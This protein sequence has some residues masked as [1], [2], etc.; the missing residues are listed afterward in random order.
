MECSSVREASSS[1][2]STDGGANQSQEMY[3]IQQ[4][5]Q[6]QALTSLPKEQTLLSTV[7][8]FPRKVVLFANVGS[9]SDIG[10]KDLKESST[11]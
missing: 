1:S 11:D 3:A 7:S 4:E 5:G 9:I 2:S 8:A 10:T 6:R